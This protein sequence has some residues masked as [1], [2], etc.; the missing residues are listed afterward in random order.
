MPAMNT[1]DAMNALKTALISQ[2]LAHRATWLAA[3]VEVEGY[4]TAVAL[5]EKE[6]EVISARTLLASLE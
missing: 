6:P 4:A 3:R 2:L 1:D 5:F